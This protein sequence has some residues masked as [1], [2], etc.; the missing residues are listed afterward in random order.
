M[1]VQSDAAVAPLVLGEPQRKQRTLWGDV[2]V[3]FRQHTLAMAGLTV[4]FI[5]VFG[6]AVGPTIYPVDP[7]H[8]NIVDSSQPPSLDHPFGTD[9]L[10]RDLLA[11][12][13]YGGRISLSV[14]I[15]AMLVAMTFGTLIGII[16]GYFRKM[17][18]ILMRFTDMMLALP[19]LPLLLVI[20]MLFRDTLRKM[21][22]PEAG[23]F[24]LVVVVIGILGWMPTSRVVR[25]SVLSIKEKEFVEASVSVGTHQS[26][27]LRRHIFPNVL[28]PII[29]SAT[30]G[31]A[32][33]ILTES[34][35]SFLGL[36]FP[37]D[38]PTWGRL[39][40]DGK[41]FMTFTPWVIIWPGLLIS[42]TV[43]S[44]NFM[45]DGLRDALD[46]RQRK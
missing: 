37:P 14:G 44:I 28:S 23:I 20:I 32:A 11:R 22:G 19:Q 21:F 42:L 39:L 26:R 29:V 16:A 3:R 1:A 18:N 41:D 2:W 34:A 27:I 6:V 25:G 8:I 46:P 13:I 31:V 17:D 40:F 5:L 35:L 36:G 43:L 24:I 4:W 45:G 30:L 10:G 15:V 12:N 38:V 9:D 33:A 7:D